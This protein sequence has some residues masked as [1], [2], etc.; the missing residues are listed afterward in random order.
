[1]VRQVPDYALQYLI[2]HPEFGPPLSPCGADTPVREA[3][4][5]GA[6]QREALTTSVGSQ[7]DD[8]PASGTAS[9]TTEPAAK[10]RQ[11]AAHGASRGSTIGND[12]APKQRKKPERETYQEES[13]LKRVQAAITGA[14]H[15]DWRDLRTVFEFAGID[16]QNK[17]ASS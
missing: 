1:M 10:R 14:E 6:A 15:G 17:D 5:T 13:E 12:R 3:K 4:P 16:A 8:S 9:I 2:E 7:R 11:N